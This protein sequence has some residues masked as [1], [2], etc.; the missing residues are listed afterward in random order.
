MSSIRLIV[1]PDLGEESAHPL[2]KTPFIIGRD[3]PADLILDDPQ[4]S[5][6]HL[7]LTIVGD[8][9]YVRDYSANGAFISGVRMPQNRSIPWRSDE[10]LRVGD[11]LLGEISASC[12]LIE[13]GGRSVSNHTVQSRHLE[14][15]Q[16]YITHNH[17]LN[18]Y[19]RTYY[20]GWVSLHIF[21]RA[22]LLAV[23]K[24]AETLP[25]SIFREWVWGKLFG[26]SD[27]AIE[28]YVE[29]RGS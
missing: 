17:R 29:C 8:A 28:E 7:E 11:F 4:I 5:R 13:R 3:E 26:Y 12:Y 19:A 27:E 24:E 25:P 16:A 9:V 15:I 18:T 20:P 1:T 23:I 10:P 2:D 6:K 21:K 22:F 14:A